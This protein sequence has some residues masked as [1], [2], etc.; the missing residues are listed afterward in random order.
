MGK[1]KSTVSDSYVDA[2]ATG[3][4]AAPLGVVGGSLIELHG[5]FYGAPFWPMTVTV[6]G[7]PCEILSGESSEASVTCKL[8]DVR[9]TTAE[10][11]GPDVFSRT[12]SA[13]TGEAALPVV[14]KLGAEG[15]CVVYFQKSTTPKFGRIAGA[16]TT[17]AS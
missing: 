4:V 1:A 13:A 9:L 7:T 14:C 17:V 11:D 16:G 12:V 15:N 6:G 2:I 5:Y 3:G 10:L 8:G